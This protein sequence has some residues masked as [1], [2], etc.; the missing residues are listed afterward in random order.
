LALNDVLENDVVAVLLGCTVPVV[1]R[2]ISDDGKGE[3]T[4]RFVGEC[5]VEGG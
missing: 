1:I 3:K 4:A 5:Y 2:T